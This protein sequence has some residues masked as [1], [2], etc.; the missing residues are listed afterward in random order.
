M[1]ENDI[2]RILDDAK[3]YLG[4]EWQYNKLTAVEKISI[5]LSSIAVVAVIAVLAIFAL[6]YIIST[7][8]HALAIWTGTYWIPNLIVATLLVVLIIV[9]LAVKQR[10]IIDPIVRYITRLFLNSSDNE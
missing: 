3:S 7:I 1:N 9:V 4:R 10:L 8:V 2:R 6:H 5:L